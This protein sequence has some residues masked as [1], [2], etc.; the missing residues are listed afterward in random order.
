M[1]LIPA[2]DLRAGRCVRL[3]EGKLHEET[4]FSEDPAAMARNWANQGARMLH[5]VDLDG[6]FAGGPR[7][8]DEIRDILAVVDIPIQVGG[9]IRTM[10]SIET[11]LGLGVQR[12]ILGTAAIYEPDLVREAID[13]Y[14]DRVIVGIDGK[15]GMVAIEGWE[16][17]TEKTVIELGREVK[18]MGVSRVVFTDTRRDGTMK[19]PNVAATQELA[20]Q[21]GLKVIASGG[22][23][24]LEDLK[25]LV[26][27]EPDGVDSII[28]GRAIYSD[29]FTLAE[30][31]ALVEGK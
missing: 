17:T 30:A 9:G 3:V 31:L 11:L 28:V 7:H 8:L 18:A 26:A 23:S 20:R 24:S 13:R 29:A 12:V 25:H 22:V 1:L 27:L 16:A 2:I 19:G 4:V 15:N 10:E 14:G 6:A 5:I 21:T